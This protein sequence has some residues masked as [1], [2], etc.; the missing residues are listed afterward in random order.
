MRGTPKERRITRKLMEIEAAIRAMP[1]AENIADDVLAAL[2]HVAR[3]EELAKE[4]T[5]EVHRR[6]MRMP[7]PVGACKAILAELP[8]Q[9]GSSISNPSDFTLRLA[10]GG[11]A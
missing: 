4:Y 3:R 5:A 11:A 6:I 8:A 10:D 9:A 7:D 1:D 2:R